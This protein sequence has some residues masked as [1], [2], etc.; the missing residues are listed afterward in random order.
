MG[1]TSA[2][3]P[4]ELKTVGLLS[5]GG[6]RTSVYHR[7]YTFFGWGYVFNFDLIDM[8]SRFDVTSV[9][10]FSHSGTQIIIFFNLSDFWFIFFFKPDCDIIKE[11]EEGKDIYIM[12]SKLKK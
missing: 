7:V 2:E 6:A 9:V 4:V 11:R 3:N 1:E 12:L 5:G 10:R 8:L